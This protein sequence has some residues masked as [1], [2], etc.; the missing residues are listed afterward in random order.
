MWL[1]SNLVVPSG[2]HQ[3]VHFDCQHRSKNY[4]LPT[5]QLTATLVSYLPD[6]LITQTLTTLNFLANIGGI[7]P[8]RTYMLER[9]PLAWLPLWFNHVYHLALS[10][11]G[12]LCY[13]PK[14]CTMNGKILQNLPYICIKLDPPQDLVIPWWCLLFIQ[15]PLPLLLHS[16][17]IPQPTWW[18]PLPVINVVIYSP[19]KW[20]KING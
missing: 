3:Y 9:N 15:H 5:H 7:Y 20:P 14:Q 6:E 12:S 16:I 1:V 19:Y 8:N 2:K 10:V 18:G 11:Q 4:F 13:Q 17:P